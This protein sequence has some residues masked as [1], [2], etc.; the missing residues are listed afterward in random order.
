M[1]CN[2]PKY[3]PTEFSIYGSTSPLVYKQRRMENFVLSDIALESHAECRGA[4]GRKA[5]PVTVGAFET[6]SVKIW[7]LH[8]RISRYEEPAGGFCLSQVV[9]V[10]SSTQCPCM[11]SRTGYLHVLLQTRVCVLLR[12]RVHSCYSGE[13][14]LTLNCV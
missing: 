5:A 7:F 10:V 3:P 9:Y 13:D 1:T 2:L 4:G 12:M 11:L 6:R 8:G 14:K